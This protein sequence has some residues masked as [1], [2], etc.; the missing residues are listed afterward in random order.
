MVRR[1][2]LANETKTT[3]R[4]IKHKKGVYGDAH[5]VPDHPRA[6][7]DAHACGQRPGYE[8]D[9]DRY[10]DDRGNA[11]GAKNRRNDEREKRVAD[12]GNGLEEGAGEGLVRQC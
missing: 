6:S 8:H 10:P 3:Q 11:Y 12:Y 1:A 2:A 7:H 9:I 5:A 4:N